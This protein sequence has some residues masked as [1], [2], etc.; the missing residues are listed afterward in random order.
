MQRYHAAGCTS[1]VNNSSIGGAS[2]RDTARADSSSL[3][4][5][6]SLNRR[7]SQLSPYKLKC[8]K[9]SLNSRLGPPDY[10]PQTTN[11][12]EE[13]LT[14]EYVQSGYRETVEGVEESREISLTQ[15]QSFTKPVVVKCKESIRKC[16][17]AI[18]ESRAQKRKAGQVYGV[19]LSDSLLTKPGVFP[20]QRPCSEDFRKKWIEVRH[21]CWTSRNLLFFLPH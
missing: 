14:K 10:H 13:T 21:S 6:Y 11:C 7:P 9:E 5:N 8:D 2:A 3:P 4:T 18:N 15:V 17:R 12:P 19:P 16:L 1:A 20:D